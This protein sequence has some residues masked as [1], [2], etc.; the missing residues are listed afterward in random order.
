MKKRILVLCALPYT[1]NIPHIGNIVGSHLPADIFARFCRMKG[2]EVLF[3]GGADENG[4]TS[5]IA[6][7]EINVDVKK[8]LDVLYSIHKKIYDWFN[9]SYDIFSRTSK[10][11][12]HDVVKKFFL[13]IKENGFVSEGEM[14]LPFC[15]KCGIFLTDRYV[16]GTCPN[17]KYENARGDQCE[18]CSK[19]LDPTD[20]INPKCKLCG[21]KP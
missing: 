18:N 16:Y 19:I 13:K 4:S 1:N 8:F 5:E 2:Y 6:A 10:E 3:V 17:C 21:N 20:L 7:R 15:N 12:H 9:I 14:V 11:I